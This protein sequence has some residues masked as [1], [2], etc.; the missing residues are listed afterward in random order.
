[1]ATKVSKGRYRTQVYLGT[2]DGKKKT[3]VFYAATA[4]EAD[5]LAL[6]FKLQKEKSS[7]P[8]KITVGEAVDQYIES[9][10]NL[11]SP[12]TITGYRV[13]RRNN[14]Q[15][16]M[17]V[18]V[19]DVTTQMLQK[20]VNA[21]AKCYSPK[22]VKCAYNVLL[23]GIGMYRPDFTPKI[24][25]PKE[26]QIQYATPDGETLMR[27]FEVS[28]GTRL[29]IPILLAAWLSL[30]ASEVIGLKWTDVYEDHIHVQTARVYSDQGTVEKETKTESSNRKIPLPAYIKNILDNTPHTSEYVCDMTGAAL[31]KAFMRMLKKHNIPHCRFH[32]LRHANAS[33]MV[34][35][36]VPDRYAQVRGG[37]ATGTVLTRRYQQT[38]SDE[39]IRIAERIDTYF[40]SLM[41]TKIHTN[42]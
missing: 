26:K 22:S 25:L 33:V 36:G 7:D 5:Y 8:G 3:K 21:E 40:D 11:L 14:F 23:L 28:K 34:M 18:R 9:K 35:L 10:S 24:T 17:D 6:Q 13:K 12:S 15:S 38:F 19:A 1:M 29:E 30:R 20:A 16:L 37:W 42:E 32:D 31:Y 41:H 2:V 4:A 39:E 27:I